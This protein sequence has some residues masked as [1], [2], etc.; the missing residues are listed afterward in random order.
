[1]YARRYLAVCNVKRVCSISKDEAVV[2]VFVSV[3]SEVGKI[4]EILVEM[5]YDTMALK[6]R[7]DR[8]N[9]FCKAPTLSRNE[10]Y[11]YPDLYE[12]VLIDQNRNVF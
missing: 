8:Q 11:R 1:M 10:R 6:A 3:Y 5:G 12:R 9:L 7:I 4:L 2:A